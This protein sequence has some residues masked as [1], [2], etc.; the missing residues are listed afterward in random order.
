MSNFR[1]VQ[2][3]QLPGVPCPCGIAQRAFGDASGGAISVHLVDI[4][5]DAEAH[6]HKKMTEIYVIIEG[7][8]H[9]ELDGELVAVRPLSAV[10]IKPGCRHRAIGKL[11]I[12][13]IPVPAFDERDEYAA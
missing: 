12:I 10:M 2:L 6:Y 5:Q 9:L 1:L 4:K 3:D 7:E 11:R 13:N 8:G